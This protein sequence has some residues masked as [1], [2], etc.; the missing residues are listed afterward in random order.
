MMAE[1]KV[2]VK[3]S[4]AEA[5]RQKPQ[6]SISSIVGVIGRDYLQN[7]EEVSPLR[8]D[9]NKSIRSKVKSDQIQDPEFKQQM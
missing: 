7:D 1:K 2:E 6:E 4:N 9:Y 8:S 3:R 5:Q